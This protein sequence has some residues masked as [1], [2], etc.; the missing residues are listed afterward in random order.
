MEEDIKPSEE[1]KTN[2]DV[3]PTDDYKLKVSVKS[4]EH[5]KPVELH[6]SMAEVYKS[7]PVKK[8]YGKIILIII[9][10]IVISGSAG[11]SAYWW[12]DKTATETKNSQSAE[13]LSLTNEK[14]SLEKQLATSKADNVVVAIDKI[15]VAP[16]TVIAP[17]AAVIDNIKASIT[18]GNTAALSGYMAP[19]VNV[20]LA[21]TEGIGPSTPTSAVASITNFITSV[22]SSWDYNF[23]LPVATLA[24]YSSGGYKVYFPS[25]AVVGKAS[26]GKVISFSFDCSGKISTVFMAASGE[27]L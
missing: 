8:N 19:S 1:N 2:S 7:K 10:V 21:A 12:R 20:I 22:T 13:I 25:T 11:V 24:S 9:L 5:D 26:N 4:N 3:K 15:E 14:K 18:S 16:C 6:E 17:T 27:L 23:S